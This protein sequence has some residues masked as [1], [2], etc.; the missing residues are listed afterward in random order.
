MLQH[1]LVSVIDLRQFLDFTRESSTNL[2]R[3]LNREEVLKQLI[4]ISLTSI[5]KYQGMPNFFYRDRE[6]K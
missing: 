4:L 5:F 2:K 3:S 1:Q 6:E